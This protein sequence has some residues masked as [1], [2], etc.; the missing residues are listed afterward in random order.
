MG[1]IDQGT[2]STRFCIVN[3]AGKMVAQHQIEHKQI[4]P[5]V[6]AS[7]FE[8]FRCA[9]DFL[10]L[11]LLDASELMCHQFQLRNVSILPVCIPKARCVFHSLRFTSLGGWSMIRWKFG[12]TQKNV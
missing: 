6:G 5:E 11:R 12:T 3:H 8:I 7:E 10:W 1:A 2:S 4:Y 9:K